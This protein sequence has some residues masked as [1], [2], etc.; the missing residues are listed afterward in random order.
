[1]H[2]LTIYK[3]LKMRIDAQGRAAWIEEE[4]Q[5]LE[6]PA[7]YDLSPEHAWER[8]KLRDTRP[9]A[10]AIAVEVAAWREREAQSRDQPRGRVLKDE[11]IAEII[12][13]RPLTKEALEKLR[14]V[15]RGWA[16]SDLATGLLAAVKRGLD[17]AT[18]DLPRI[19]PRRRDPIAPA[20]VD[21]L[22]A[23]LR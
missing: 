8:L 16:N 9:R 15:P 13:E 11:L 23:L 4:M 6:D 21:L 14:A 12:H 10:L 5:K 17:R 22:K 1:T 18:D 3:Y 20:R 7:A 19:S 2:L